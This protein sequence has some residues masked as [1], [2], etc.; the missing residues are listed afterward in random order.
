MRAAEPAAIATFAYSNVAVAAHTFS[1]SLSQGPT[2]VG[3]ESLAD[4]FP[5][6]VSVSR[7]RYTTRSLFHTRTSPSLTLTAALNVPLLSGALPCGLRY[8]CSLKLEPDPL[9]AAKCDLNDK[10]TVFVA[11]HESEAILGIFHTLLNKFQMFSLL[12]VYNVRHTTIDL[13]LVLP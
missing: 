9:G 6:S 13:R 3:F 1:G 2:I 5:L 8:D 7:V 4:S 10:S 11:M 12:Y